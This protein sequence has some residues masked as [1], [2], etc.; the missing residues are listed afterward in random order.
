MRL[1]VCACVHPQR[2]RER[3]SPLMIDISKKDMFLTISIHI[4]VI[5]FL[6]SQTIFVYSHAI[7]HCCLSS[8]K[9]L[10]ACLLKSSTRVYGSLTELF[11]PG[12]ILWMEGN[13][14]LTFECAKNVV[15]SKFWEFLS[16][17]TSRLDS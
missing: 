11:L 17:L 12:L 3:E 7:S 10:I 4:N 5:T 16:I 15:L 14:R 2:E 9:F 13:Q 1:C 6:Y 8:F